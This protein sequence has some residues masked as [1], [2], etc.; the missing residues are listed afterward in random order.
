MMIRQTLKYITSLNL[1]VTLAR[2]H[3]K[4]SLTAREQIKS[5]LLALPHGN[6]SI[7]MK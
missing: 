1:E 7:I 6:V 3:R 4:K 5:S 2:Q